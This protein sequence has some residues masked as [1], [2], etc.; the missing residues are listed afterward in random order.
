MATILRR[1]YLSRRMFLHGAGAT[2]G[3]PLLDAMTPALA[4][5][6][7]SAANTPRLG[8]IYV[9]NGIV[10][11]EWKPSGI[12]R[13]FELSR[14]LGPLAPLRDKLTVITGLDHAQAENFGDG[15]GDHPRSSAAWLT[16]VHAYDRT[17]PGVE[18]RL[19]TSADQLAAEALSKTTRLR[20][21][22]LSVDTA[23]QSACDSGDC[24]YVN[25][26]SWRN[27]TTPNLTENHPRVV[28]ERLFGDGGSAQERAAQARR[29]G[30]ILDSVRGEAAS[31]AAALGHSDR[32]KLSEY[33][34][35]VREIEQ[36][37]ANTE[38][39]GGHGV[40]LPQRPTSIPDS[41][42]EHTRL[43]MDLLVLAWQ[44]DTTR[45]GS[46]LLAREV[47]S[48]AYPH[49][50]VPDQHHPVSHHRNDPQLIEK[51]SKI[52]TYHVSLLGYMAQKMAAIPD[53]DG[54]L[55][56]N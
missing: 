51:K 31:L 55:L 26:I 21:L 54:T 41:Y 6:R 29:T 33:L 2:L 32:T 5:R 20:S 35:S 47:S 10:H 34:E 28:F 4:Q 14:N 56:D 25:T 22:E 19:A 18:V 11:Q 30:S 48:R 36:R 15:T 23:T 45:I 8:F 13:E 1:K 39:T 27:E 37:I 3:L 9:G 17:Q 12:G 50:G 46:V 44:S 16:G 24:F 40:V 38:S 52:D 7:D 49:I 42:D 43:M 53:G